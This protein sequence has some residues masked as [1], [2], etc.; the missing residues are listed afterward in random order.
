MKKCRASKSLKIRLKYYKSRILLSLTACTT[1]W[2]FIFLLTV[3]V[4]WS[5]DDMEHFLPKGQNRSD[6]HLWSSCKDHN[7]GLWLSCSILHVWS[8]IWEKGLDLMH[9]WGFSLSY[10][11]P[12]LSSLWCGMGKCSFCVHTLPQEELLIDEAFHREVSD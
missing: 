2:Y 12:S 1:L 10:P 5:M 4:S 3:Q 9:R 7:L 11:L 6:C 8:G